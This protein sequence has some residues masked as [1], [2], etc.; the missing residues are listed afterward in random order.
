MKTASYSVAGSCRTTGRRSGA[1]G[2][3]ASSRQSVLRLVENASPPLANGN[4]RSV[5][6]VV[7]ALQ[8]S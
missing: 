4:A 2:P 5:S 7:V 8:S 6:L 1:S 3:L